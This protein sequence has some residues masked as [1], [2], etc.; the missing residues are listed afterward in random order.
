MVF[1]KGFLT[2]RSSDNIEGNTMTL[3]NENETKLL[4]KMVYGINAP[5]NNISLS[6]IGGENWSTQRKPLACRKSLTNFVT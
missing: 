4:R 2:K 6:F 3:C 5:L 1:S